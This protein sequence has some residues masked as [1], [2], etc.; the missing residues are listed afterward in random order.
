MRRRVTR[1]TMA[2]LLRPA[3]ERVEARVLLATFMVTNTNDDTNMGSLRWAIGQSNATPGGNTIDF[4]IAPVSGPRVATIDV[5]S[6]LP[7]IT[8][9]VYIDG[10]SEQ[11]DDVS[12]VPEIE[13]NGAN[14]GKGVDG[15]DVTAGL[16]TIGGLDV[17]QFSG[18]GINLS[19]A[20]G[21]II[22]GN[23]IGTNLAGTVAEGNG[24]DG[25]LVQVN[26]NNNQIAANLISGNTMNGVYL[27]GQ[28]FGAN[29]P[30]TSGNLIGGNLIGT[31]ATG[32]VTLGNGKDGIYVQNAPQTTI[33]GTA[34]F[35]RN[36]ISGNTNGMELYDNSDNSVIE[37]NYIGTD[38]TGSVALGNG[39]TGAVLGDGIVLKGMSNSTIGGTVPGSGNVIS[40]NGNYGID[41]FVIGSGNIAIQGNLIGTDATGTKPLGN[42][43][44]SLV[45]SGVFIWGESNVTI[46]GSTAGA[47]NVIS[48]NVHEGITT[49]AD[50]PGLLIEGNDIGTDAT[51]KLNLGNG[52]DGVDATY[53]GIT[54]GGLQPQDANVIANNGYTAVFDHDGV[55]VT[56]NDTSVLSNSIYN[57]MNL[58]IDLN[59]GNNG[60]AA[61]VL[62]SAVSLGTSS[63][64]IGSLTAAAGSYTLQFFS[65]PSLNPSGN[66]EGE[67][68][69]GTANVTVV[70]ASG[71]FSLVL[72]SGFAAGSL[73]TA[74]ATDSAGNTSQF[75]LPVTATG[76]GTGGGAPPTITASA[77]PSSV[78]AGQDVTDTFT[79]TNPYTVDDGGLIFSDPIPAGT[80]FVSGTTSTGATVLLAGGVATAVIGAL[81]ALESITVNIVLA[82]S[83]ASIPSFT[84]VGEISTTSPPVASSASVTND[85]TSSA[86]LSVSIAGPSG[87]TL[88]GQKLTYVVKVTNSGPSVATG[89]ILTDTLPTGTTLSSAIPNSGPSPVTSMGEVTDDY[90]TL[91]PG[92]SFT[93]TIVVTAGANSAPQATDTASVMNPNET[94]PNSANNTMFATATVTPTA[95]VSVTVVPSAGTVNVG[96]E[97]TYQVTVANNGPSPATGVTLTDTLPP[98]V[99]FVSAVSNSGPSPTQSSGVVSD[100]IGALADHG[101]VVVTIIVR[102]TGFAASTITDSAKVMANEA[103]VAAFNNT[104]VAATNVTPAAD[105]AILKTSAA[106][107]SVALGG[108]VAITI[109]ATNNG[110]SAATGAAV[111]DT[112]PS[113]LTFVSGSVAGGTVT[114]LGGVVTANLGNLVSG[115]VSV[116]TIVATASAVGTFTTTSTVASP[117]VNDPVPGNDTGAATVT[118]TPQS[119]LAVVL[120]SS[121]ASAFTG[122][123]LTYTAVVTNN[124]PSPATNVV[125]TD[126]LFAGASFQS[127]EANQ[128]F[129][130]A[131]NGLVTM[132]LGTIASG[133]SVTVVLVVVPTQPGVVT[134]TGTVTTTQ[135]DPN[136]GNNVSSV[137]TTVI[138]AYRLIQFA[139]PTYSA[140][141]TGGF[142]TIALNRSGDL[143]GDLTVNFST[144][145]GGDA[146]PGLDYQPVSYTV[147]FPQGVTQEFATVP[148]LVDPYDNHDESV[149]LQLANPTSGAILQLGPPA[150]TAPTTA[151]LQIVDVNPVLDG[152]TVTDL[153]L[154]GPVNAV[155]SIEVDTSGNLNPSTATL[156]TN[157]SI[158]ALGGVK[159]GLAAGTVVPVSLATY[160]TSTGAVTLTLAAPLSANEFFQVDVNGSRPGA[161]TDRAGNPLNSVQG[162]AP[163]SDYLLQVVRGTNIN[164]RDENGTPVTLKLTG[165]GALDLDRSVNGQVQR[166]QVVGAA[167]RKTTVSGTVHSASHRTTIGSIL[168]LGQFGSIQMKLTTPPFYV[169]NVTYPNAKSLVDAPAVDSLIAPAPKK[170]APKTK[171]KSTASVAQQS[172]A[173]MAQAVVAPK[174]PTRKVAPKV[175]HKVVPKVAPKAIPLKVKPVVS[176]AKHPHAAT[177]KGKTAR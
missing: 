65:T 29:N 132:P 48:S 105:L 79:I 165:P 4:D 85:V 74:T 13:I 70:G 122:D 149:T 126:P 124:G 163:G 77:M 140:T 152:P 43:Y 30:V 68:L 117:T 98:N 177:P 38:A 127:V 156:A 148:V 151:T 12:N 102:P 5:L 10:F 40:G 25:I 128:V 164:Y 153:K 42:G 150:S 138:S 141:E 89:V 95:D 20:G 72:P 50:G 170:P 63:T 35:D 17:D 115:G 108:S 66:A 81:P 143:L 103:D 106:P 88:V 135:P 22:A 119:D 55:K 6:A 60:Q 16:T 113:G 129:G 27:N 62:T 167:G 45:G 3:V 23:F 154:I 94:D 123:P 133:A 169:T 144:V 147:Y 75:S 142:A 73:I 33:G 125:F 87:A 161:V 54:I 166:L 131:V 120:G 52:G 76:S 9:P 104:T 155:T 93:L 61:P 130:T 49:F 51:G 34:A 11:N 121:A 37:G 53:P 118:V 146:T 69:L 116:V 175:V 59:G 145:G 32:E 101:L 83:I 100:A 92:A 162:S 176:T 114:D 173:V 67:T 139:S 24:L 82:T 26:S 157:Y 46:G 109:V 18:E 91:A 78:P 21:N 111:T 64:I 159:G 171:A 97:L 160:N 80:T 174:P 168:G 158:T 99:T 7:T 41:S 86:D 8:V 14:A 28:L 136:P 44:T 137:T 84:N 36:V 58:G 96:D 56:A 15:L 57:S 112:L 47:G 39:P 2:R 1:K 19:K 172:H 110:P 90:G 31:D 107:S 134:N 71:N